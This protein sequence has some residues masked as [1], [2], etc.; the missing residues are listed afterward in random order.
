MTE[1]A[2]VLKAKPSTISYAQTAFD[3][4]KIALIDEIAGSLMM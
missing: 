2:P 4:S 1:S 3:P